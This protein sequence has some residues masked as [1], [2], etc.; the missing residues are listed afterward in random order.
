MDAQQRLSSRKLVELRNV[1]K[2]VVE[3]G[4]TGLQQLTSTLPAK[5]DEERWDCFFFFPF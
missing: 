1:V 3:E 5:S 2:N 4:W